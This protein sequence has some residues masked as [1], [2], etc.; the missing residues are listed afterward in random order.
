M[1]QPGILGFEGHPCRDTAGFASLLCTACKGHYHPAVGRT[2]WVGCCSH[3][4]NPSTWGPLTLCAPARVH[5]H[6]QRA[7]A[8]A[9]ALAGSA[10]WLR[11]LGAP[12]LNPSFEAPADVCATSHGAKRRTVT[13]CSPFCTELLFYV[14]GVQRC[15]LTT[16]FTYILFVVE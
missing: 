6:R 14:R 9:L 3:V 2:W 8:L 12:P 10:T 15:R 13:Y 1:Q 16:L 5:L 11:R 7:V 4:Y